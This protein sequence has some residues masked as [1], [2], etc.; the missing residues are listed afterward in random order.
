[1]K[2]R[3]T[4][5]RWVTPCLPVLLILVL[6]CFVGTQP[7]FAQTEGAGASPLEELEPARA[8]ASVAPIAT[9][10]QDLPRLP[11][12]TLNEEAIDAAI[13][14]VSIPPVTVPQPEIP[15]DIAVPQGVVQTG[16]QVY[17]DATLGGGSVNSILGS[18]NVYRLGDGPEFR[19]GYDHRGRD[20]FNFEPPGTGFFRRSN[21]L[22]AWVRLG[23]DSP[24]IVEI[25]G[26]YADD[27]FGLQ[28]LSPFYAQEL[29][30]FSGMVDLTYDPQSVLF[31]RT[32]VDLSSTARVLST[33]DAGIDAETNTVT[34]IEPMIETTLEWPRFRVGATGR[35][36]GVLPGG[37][38]IDRS[39]ILDLRL[40]VETIPV[41]G[42]TFGV[43]GATA[44]RID[45]GVYFPVEAY[46]A[47]QGD[48]RWDARVGA[49]TEI[50]VISV[51]DYWNEY[52][53]LSIEP[54]DDIETSEFPTTRRVF[55]EGELGVVV[56]PNRVSLRGGITAERNRDNVIVSDFDAVGDRYALAV[57][58]TETLEGRGTVELDLTDYLRLTGGW[59]GLWGDV[60][61]GETEHRLSAG[62][63]ISAERFSVDIGAEMPLAFSDTVVPTV[64]LEG[65]YQFSR[66]VDLSVFAYDVL[67]PVMEN[68]RTLRGIAP[69]DEDPL[70][71]PGL[72]IGAAVRVRF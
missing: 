45:D 9:V 32:T 21:D 42:L 6:G 35:Y 36:R 38:G 10:V 60:L 34:K 54:V 71:G 5:A 55:A 72:E 40:G 66:D 26:A 41:D 58:D 7:S 37:T 12:P 22:D 25:E 56:I 8:E 33:G 50:D 63:G 59:T 27:Q 51:S 18:I 31:A 14:V 44:Y 49:G 11:P 47:Y 19:V 3:V 52:P 15:R 61:P 2:R 13:E 16:D 48:Q 28:Q 4:R 69:N 62:I 70:I 30:T 17:F 64:D 68:G 20:G 39:S 1:M 67:S 65:M 29:R 23:D 46:A 57:E 53:L 24:L 43:E